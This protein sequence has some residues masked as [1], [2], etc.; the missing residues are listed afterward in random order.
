MLTGIG[1][2]E[3]LAYLR[4]DITIEQLPVRMAQSNRQYARRQLRWWRRDSRVRWFDIEPNGAMPVTAI[5]NYLKE[6]GFEP[7]VG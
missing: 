4:G 6:N 5:L 3:A 2:A 7:N 1:Y